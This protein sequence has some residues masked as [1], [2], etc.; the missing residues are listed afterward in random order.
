MNAVFSLTKKKSSWFIYN[1]L[2]W[3]PSDISKCFFRFFSHILQDVFCDFWRRNYLNSSLFFHIGPCL[4]ENVSGRSYC[5]HTILCH[6]ELFFQQGGHI[7]L[8]EVANVSKIF[9]TE[10]PTGT[11]K[12]KSSTLTNQVTLCLMWISLAHRTSHCLQHQFQEDR[13]GWFYS[14]R[15]KNCEAIFLKWDA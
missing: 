7:C 11:Q 2:H 6:A 14:T 9:P 12:P 3:D 15:K 5:R 10:A 4:R 1:S 13:K 8:T